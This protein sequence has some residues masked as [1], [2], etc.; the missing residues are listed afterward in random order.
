MSAM[1]RLLPALLLLAACNPPTVPPKPSPT[2]AAPPSPSPAAPPAAL[3]LKFTVPDG[4]VAGP[5]SSRMRKAQ[6]TVPDRNKQHADAVLIVSSFGPGSGS[7][8][9]NTGRWKEEMGGADA[10]I[11]PVE[12]A[13][14]KTTVVDISGAWSGGMGGESPVDNARMLMGV[15]ETSGGVWYF[16]F[17]GPSGTVDGW[18]DSF[19]AMLRAIQE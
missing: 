8:E 6:Y 1:K 3:A 19:L 17:V 9:Q 12:G 2:A 10:S 14:L 5:P 11:I 7:L 16:K 13:A 18:K 15:V 4:W